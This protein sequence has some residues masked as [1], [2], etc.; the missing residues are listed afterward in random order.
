M[1]RYIF[2]EGTETP[3]AQALARKRQIADQLT[4]RSVANTPRNLG[5][6]LTAIGQAIAGRVKDRRLQPKEQAERDRI[7]AMLSGGGFGMGA[8]GPPV[9]GATVP[10]VSSRPIDPNAPQNIA[11]DTMAAL[12]QPRQR[13][14]VM[15]PEV[16]AGI[17]AG[18]SGGDYDALYGYSN[19]GG[20]FGNVR[21]TEMTVG[22][23]MNFTQPRGEYGQWVKGQIG[24]VATP[25]GAYQVVGTTLRGA[26]EAGVL[27]PDEQFTP[28]VQDRLGDWI[29]QTQGLGAWEGYRGPR[30]PSS[31]RG[32]GQ[33]RGGG[34]G[35]NMSA[36]MLAEIMGN[37]YASEGQ[38]MVAQA[39]MQQQMQ[40][41][42]PMRQLQ[43]QQL[44][45]QIA[46]MGQP[47]PGYRQ[48]SGAE[49]GLQG[50][51]AGA[52]FN[53][54]PDG[55]ISQIGG[56]GTNVTVNTG[57]EDSVW[58]KPEAGN[59]WL[60]NA[61]GQ[62]I[63]E[64]DPS[65]AGVRPRQVPIAGGSIEREQQ[66]ASQSRERQETLTGRQLNPT[67]DDIVTARDL[68]SSGIGRTGM[69][70]D[71]VKNIPGFGQG[72]LDLSATVDAIGSGISL[73]NLN[74]MRQA[75]PTGGALGNVSDKQ[76]AL[77]SEAFGSLRQSQSRELFLYNLARVENTLNDIVHGEGNG[78]ER[79]DMG[80]MREGLRG[81][82]PPVAAAAPIP[83]GEPQV[84][85][86]AELPPEAFRQMDLAQ[87][88]QIDVMRLTPEQA[89]AM[90]ERLTEL[91][92]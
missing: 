68:A 35:G 86:P 69:I 89:A 18:E 64:P 38:K 60:R 39:I 66:D 32:G 4:A 26:V 75:S 33:A 1:L 20:R 7:A 49:L 41:N 87:I 23:V 45:M 72:A 80:K 88:S 90:A 67:I 58:G 46:Q 65:G 91:G 6:G 14:T 78:P 73:E 74:Q 28:E 85:D 16:R 81:G 31:V 29:L 40:A 63:T 3:D 30:D 71:I 22:E 24:R 36:Q 17:F 44:Q 76:S 12:G 54:G 82:A 27:R 61:E 19:R 34:G 84:I 48:V 10:P 42:D 62:V 70:S 83:D 79:H 2:G 53:V 77:L 13:T 52:L 59:V 37:P 11:D 47:Q 8:G 55:K 50:D 25:V 43:M 56:A 9:S 5:E 51:Q 57:A 21:P 92:Y 15:T